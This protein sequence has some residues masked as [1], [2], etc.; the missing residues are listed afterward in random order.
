ML[1]F[2]DFETYFYDNVNVYDGDFAS[3][4]Y[5]YGDITPGYGR[6]LA[7]YSGSYYGSTFGQPY[8]LYSD[9]PTM[10]ISF[11]SYSGNYGYKGFKALYTTDIGI[12]I[13]IIFFIV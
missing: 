11:N 2:S 6:L 13:E 9:S 1:D 12:G 7:S 8:T 4:T 10:T 3:T 5:D